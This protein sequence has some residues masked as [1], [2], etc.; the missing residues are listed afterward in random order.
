[1]AQLTSGPLL[2]GSLPSCFVLFSLPPS[3][4]GLGGGESFAGFGTTLFGQQGWKSHLTRPGLVV[5]GAVLRSASLAL[6]LPSPLAGGPPQLFLVLR[7][8][9]CWDY[10]SRCWGSCAEK[11]DYPR[12]AWG[13]EQ[14]V[15]F[16]IGLCVSPCHASGAAP[17]RWQLAG[18]AAL[19][20]RRRVRLVKGSF[21]PASAAC[22]ASASCFNHERSRA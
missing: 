1:M 20:E 22:G 16:G 21:L 17:S 14:R 13:K 12:P 19:W 4:T 3:R 15:R 8:Q 5:R 18:A 6:S 10:L 11:N 2:R 7:C 9:L